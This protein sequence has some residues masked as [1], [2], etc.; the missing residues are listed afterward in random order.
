MTTILQPTCAK[1]TATL[2]RQGKFFY[3]FVV[4][5]LLV[6]LFPYLEKPGL[7]TIVFR[8]L[9]ASAF[10]AGVYAVSDKRAQR[11]TAI[12]LGTLAIA[13]HILLTVRPDP[14]LTAPTLLCTLIF[15]AFTLVCLLRAV[16][17]AK[18]VTHDTIY[19][20]LSVYLL[21]AVTWGVAYLLLAT[22]QPA[23]LFIDP[24]RHP[25]H[26][27]DWSDCMFYS[28]V[29]LTSLGSDIVPMSQQARSLSML[30]TVSGV[31]YVAVLIARLVS[32]YSIS[33]QGGAKLNP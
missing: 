27:T 15:L 22:F 31:L 16:L 23:A 5:V 32:L 13:L 24:V 1:L 25:N 30:E 17:R 4:Q 28:F 3:L 29:T 21:M 18:E 19:G 7:P 33:R 11:I 12:A 20:S 10:L 14:R 8:M 9:A 2:R 26:T 6:A